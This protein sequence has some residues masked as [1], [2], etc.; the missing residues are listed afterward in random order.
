M[1]KLMAHFAEIDTGNRVLR[2]V[3]V[4]NR[5]LLDEDG[6][7]SEDLGIDFLKKH[8]AGEWRQ[9]SYNTRSGV[10]KLGGV[11]MRANYA[12]IGWLWSEEHTI[13]HPPQPYPSWILN[14][15]NGEWVPPVPRPKGE[16]DWNEDEQKWDK[17]D[18]TWV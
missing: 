4:D 14:V 10:H 13:F 2:V 6:N 7:E 15:A 16:W 12:G 5:Q 17:K 9:T 1:A 18:L 3:A 11:P 8:G